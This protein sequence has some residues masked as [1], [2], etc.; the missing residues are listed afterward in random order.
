M[1]D[2]ARR[3]LI[4]GALGRVQRRT[5]RNSKRWWTGNGR[6]PTIIA[7]G[8][9]STRSKPKPGGKRVAQDHAARE[10]AALPLLALT[11]RLTPADKRASR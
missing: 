5:A 4:Y 3:A 8:V 9:L 6:E 1:M 10:A 2:G 7:D 11:E